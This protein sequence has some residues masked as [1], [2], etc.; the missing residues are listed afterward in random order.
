MQFKQFYLS[1]LAHA[2]YYI[3][4]GAEAAIVDPQRDVSQYLHE[5]E[6]NNQRIKYIIETHLH[7]DF[8]SG[9]AELARRTGAQIVFGARANAE[10][11]HLAV[12]DGDMFE[13]GKVKLKILETPGHPP[14]GITIVVESDEGEPSKILTGDEEEIPPA[15]M[16]PVVAQKRRFEARRVGQH[17]SA[18]VPHVGGDAKD[19]T[20]E[21]EQCR[22]DE[23]DE[24]PRY[25]PGEGRAVSWVRH[26]A[27]DRG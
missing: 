22:Y 12:K 10:I 6:A 16:A 11:E 9:H 15:R 24:R 13:V 17:S 18:Q 4:S 26:G 27:F 19:L 14:E 21:E 7:A 1:C 23:S 20:A 8:V 5:A 2:S 25:I 3:G